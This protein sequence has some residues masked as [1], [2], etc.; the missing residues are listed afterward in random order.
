[1]NNHLVVDVWSLSTR[2]E[3][4]GPIIGID[5]G[6]S[7]SCIAIWDATKSRAKVIKNS[8]SGKR[9]TPSVLLF[10]G[11]FSTPTILHNDTMPSSST[12]V[13]NWKRLL[14]CSK[15]ELS[16][17][18]MKNL[19]AEI[20]DSKFLPCIRC[21]LIAAKKTAMIPLE[22]LSSHVLKDLKISAE[23]Y[24]KKN[25]ELAKLIGGDIVQR[26]VIGVPVALSLSFFISPSYLLTYLLSCRHIFLVQ[27]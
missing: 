20:D 7:T 8:T 2:Q 23:N 26:A 25:K 27:V 14:S 1:M 19:H 12:V 6:T 10:D 9:T 22:V 15:D 21:E 13:A 17:G 16:P 5:L 4:R 3:N 24:L 18:I 11:S